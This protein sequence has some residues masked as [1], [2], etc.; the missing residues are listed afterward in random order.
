MPEVHLQPG[1]LSPVELLL[2]A[3]L[4]PSKREAR[5]LVEQG[6]LSMDGVV[7]DDPSIP[8]E[9]AEGARLKLGKRWRLVRLG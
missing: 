7:L 3:G 4:A 9:P 1:P 5:R 6:A 8:V 2:A